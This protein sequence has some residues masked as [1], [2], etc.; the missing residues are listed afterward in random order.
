MS[1]RIRPYRAADRPALEALFDEFQEELVATDDL[2]RIWRPPGF[3][4]AAAEQCLREVRDQEGQLLVAEAGGD[5][6]GFAAGIVATLSPADDL[7]T[8]AEE[9][10]G[11]V[12][13]LYVRLAA[14]RRGIAREL[15]ARLDRHFAA[16]GCAAVRIE[17]FAPNRGARQ[18]YER[19]GYR[20]RNVELIRLLPP[21]AGGGGVAEGG[22]AP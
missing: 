19:V 16:A 14:R 11:R 4:A 8:R 17:V 18:F 1:V 5:A 20:E 3:G 6:V 13:E 10:Y 15:L 21:A 2:G 9:R 22:I 7:S 12:T